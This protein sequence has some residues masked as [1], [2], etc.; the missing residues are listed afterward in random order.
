[1]FQTSMMI[2]GVREKKWM[3]DRKQEHQQKEKIYVGLLNNTTNT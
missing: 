2:C 3:W 1:M